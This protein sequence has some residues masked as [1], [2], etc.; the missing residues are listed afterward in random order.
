MHSSNQFPREND[1][2]VLV[3]FICG[4][5]QTVLNLSI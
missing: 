5:L 3:S 1:V 2:D 4:C